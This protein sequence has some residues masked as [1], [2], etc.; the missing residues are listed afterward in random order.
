MS[1]P[2][3]PHVRVRDQLAGAELINELRVGG[4]RVIG[5][6]MHH[7]NGG[8]LLKMNGPRG[9][10]AGEQADEGGGGGRG[11]APS[12]DTDPART[13]RD[14]AGHCAGGVPSRLRVC[15]GGLLPG[16]RTCAPLEGGG[17]PLVGEGGGS[18][19]GEW[20]RSPSAHEGCLRPSAS[21]PRRRRPIRPRK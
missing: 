18:T 3:L 1:A 9:G 7:G 16:V 12:R 13:A 17:R 8:C 11:H 2:Y 4:L 20:D 15:V 21:L 14:T 5:R 19:G 6:P 10:G